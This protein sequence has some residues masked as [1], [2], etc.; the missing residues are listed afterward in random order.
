MPAN[1]PNDDLYRRI[2]T[3]GL[4]EARAVKMVFQLLP[5]DPRCSM[6]KSPFAGSGGSILRRVFRRYPSS[7]NPRMCNACDDFLRTHPGGAEIELTLLFADVRGSTRLGQQM[8]PTDFSDL[9]DRFYT[10][11][12][13]AIVHTDGLIEKFVGDEVASLYA[14][15]YAG[16]RHAEKAIQAATALLD[17]TG[18]RD[19]DGPWL[20]VGVGVH[21]GIAYV[22]AVGSAGVAQLTVLGDLPNTTARLAS[23]AGPGEIL[24][25]RESAAQAQLSTAD[26]EARELLLKGRDAP[27]DVYVVRVGPPA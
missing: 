23:T 16:R 18:H 11:S 1:S 24:V 7:L 21:T 4:P 12:T 2:F 8:S 10:V 22:G 6:C 20:P 19:P 25:S 5:A 3:V 27:L 14:P 15:G 17:A 13:E 9:M 26:L